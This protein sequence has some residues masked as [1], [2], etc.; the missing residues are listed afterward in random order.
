MHCFGHIHEGWGA[1][2]VTWR[3][4]SGEKAS[5]LTDIDNE[6]SVSIDNLAEYKRRLGLHGKGQV[7]CSTTS[8]C[9]GDPH[10]LKWGLQTLF[11]NAAI[12]SAPGD[13]DGESLPPTQPSWLVDLELPAATS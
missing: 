6:Q 11:V 9:L 4:Y 8:H 3:K 12:E 10:P 2:L 1:K 5:H 13:L 7:E